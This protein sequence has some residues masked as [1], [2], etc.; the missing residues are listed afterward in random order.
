M[1]W[2]PIKPKMPMPE[3]LFSVVVLI[4][5]R[6]TMKKG[7]K[8]QKRYSYKKFFVLVIR[9]KYEHVW[10]TLLHAIRITNVD[11]EKI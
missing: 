2:I 7:K 3:F 4:R 1:F 9:E 5:V 6:C 8:L 11:K 10:I